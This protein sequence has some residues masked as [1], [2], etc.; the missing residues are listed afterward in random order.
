MT[1]W[2]DLATTVRADCLVGLWAKGTA[3]SRDG[4]VIGAGR[5]GDAWR[6]RVRTAGR[7]AAP[8]VVLYPRDCEWECDCDGAFDPCEHVAACVI[9][10]SAAPGAV[11]ALFDD[12]GRRAKVRY[13][14]RSGEQGLTVRRVIDAG[15]AGERTLDS[16]LADFLAR[17]QETAGL[18]PTQADLAI[19][20][21]LGAALAKPLSFDKA[22]T[23]IRA[24]VGTE[25][26]TL[27]GEP[28]RVSAEPVHPRARVEDAGAGAVELV[29]EIDPEVTRVV[30]PGVLLRGD[31]VRPFGARDRFGQRWERLPFRRTFAGAEI[32]ELVSSVIPE[33]ERHIAVDV[34]ASR[35]PRRGG[36]VAPW[37]RFEIDFVDHGVDVLPLLV[38]GDPPAARI[39]RDRLVHLRGAIP[40][41]QPPLETNLLLRLRH[42]LDLIPG[43]RVHFAAEEAARFLA[44][45]E[46][47]D[48][49]RPGHARREALTDQRTVLMPKLIGRGEELELVFEATTSGGTPSA[50]ARGSAA[51]VVAAWRD[52]IGLVPLEDGRFGTVPAE[53]L[54]RHGELVADLLAARELNAG[55]T[56]K[57]ALALVG[58]LCDALETPAPLEVSRLRALLDTLDAEGA[59]AAAVQSGAVVPLD[60]R[61][62]LRDYQ[63]AGVAW[64]AR[65]RDAGLGAVL[66]DDMGLGKTVQALCALRGRSLVVCPRSV[67]HNWRNEIERFRPSLRVALHHGADRLLGEVDVTLT[68]YA[69]LRNDVELLGQVD[70]DCVVLD[71]SQA[72]KNPDSQVARAAYELR[73]KFRVSLSGTPIENRIDEL[74]SQMH[75]VNPGLLG[76]RRDFVER[77]ERPM[78][79]GDA[80]IGERLRRRIRPFMLRRL[81][82]EVATE[83]PPRTDAVLTCEL[84][85]HERDV[86]DAVRAAAKA[87][88]VRQLEGGASVMAVF[89]ALLRLRQAACHAGL[90]PGRTEPTSSKVEA[91]LE[92]L[93]D[94]VADGHK[95]LVFSQWTSLLD[96]VEPHLQ[97]HAIDFVRLDG[98]T[99]DRAAVVDAFQA[100]GGPP[101]FLLSLKA[102]G[103]GLNLTAA[104]YVFLLD[105]WWNPAVEEQAA[106]R[107]HRIGQDRPVM[108]YRLVAKDTVEERVLDLQRRKRALADAALSGGEQTLVGAITREDILALLD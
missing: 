77:Y 28:V 39:D 41:R 106:D 105:P 84:E 13:D 75:F 46:S 95:A 48:D 108:V 45:L 101:V 52:G 29:I 62:E 21:L 69:T 90:L 53:W 79:A 11:E 60:F 104:E 37:I 89:E 14:L 87:D 71:E 99:R 3:L 57:A 27:D 40:E 97:A 12:A 91:L 72:I 85:P 33:L 66:A 1:A 54:A 7:S 32:T 9:A 36:P 26:V 50:T 63:T 100:E 73:A 25:E 94:V 64:L 51:S 44:R 18:A 24:L 23:L 98:S 55:R 19:D 20:R 10:A 58:E 16:S 67:I 47:F 74:W 65:L 68:T 2:K 30:A 102:G 8:M 43:R 15:E 96:R 56:P 4:A 35:L 31:T 88:V 80:E 82:Q 17:R 107:A 76:G 70:W 5:E 49:G 42:E 34:R 86:Y 83:L 93:D 103:T 92:A 38:Y 6:F 78:L 81:K 22:V 61:G 59:R